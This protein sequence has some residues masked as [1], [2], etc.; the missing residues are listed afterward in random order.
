MQVFPVGVPSNATMHVAPS[1]MVML[2]PGINITRV[3]A[4]NTAEIIATALCAACAGL[5]SQQPPQPSS[6]EMPWLHK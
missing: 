6:D 1:G 4:S 5:P 3:A 2:M